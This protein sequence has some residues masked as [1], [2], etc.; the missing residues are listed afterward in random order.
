[1]AEKSSMQPNEDTKEK[2]LAAAKKVFSQKGYSAATVK[3]IVDEAGV[4][5]SLISYHFKGKEG[6]LHAC[7]ESF[8]QERMQ[9]SLRIFTAPESVE[10]LKAKL[11]LWAGLFLRLHAEENSVCA[12]IHRE[13]IDEDSILWDVFQKTF[14][15]AFEAM[16]KFF[17]AGKKKGFL[18][19]D[20][21]PHLAAAML[22]GSLSQLGHSQ[23]IQ[24]KVLGTSITNEKF[25]NQA[26]DQLTSIFLT[27]TT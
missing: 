14:L 22:Y 7:V 21:D 20:I 27:G 15:K 18:R 12:I 1:M 10:D 3:D 24:E 6:L 2:L 5:V 17:E 25:R 16:V 23:H 11:R 26:V 13:T 19:K 8:G 9:E 4:N